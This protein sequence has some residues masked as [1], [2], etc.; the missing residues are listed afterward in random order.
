MTGIPVVPGLYYYGLPLQIYCET[1]IGN[2]DD[3]PTVQCES[4]EV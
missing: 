3:H 1:E 4:L 2:Y